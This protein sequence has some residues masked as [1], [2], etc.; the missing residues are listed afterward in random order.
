MESAII[1]CK[2]AS[3]EFS[4]FCINPINM[5][6]VPGY[7]YGIQGDNGA[8]K[9]TFI[10]MIR[11]HYPS[12]NGKIFINQ[13]DVIKNK[14]NVL[15]KLAY[16]GESSTYFEAGDALY[17][18]NI[19]AP[20]YDNWNHEEYIKMLKLLQ[21]STTKKIGDMSK[22]ERV[23]FQLAFGV[24]YRPE[25]LLL[26]EPTV[27]LDPVFRDDFLKILQNFV[28]DYNTTVLLSTHLEE[29]LIKI[30]DYNITIKKGKDIEGGKNVEQKSC[31]TIELG[32]C[33][34]HADGYKYGI[35]TTY[36]QGTY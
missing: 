34:K 4:N 7:I 12:M 9:T 27:G 17:N 25:V 2:N 21:I 24:A 13:L 19:F 15:K 36:K 35:K 8:G 30:A 26:D 28:A 29:D 18:E 33:S 1:V 6:L 5:E 16:I 31:S 20:F 10:N 11:G 32:A 3:L 23:K 22:G 14:V